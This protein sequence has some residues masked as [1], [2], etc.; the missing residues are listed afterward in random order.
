MLLSCGATEDSW[1]SLGQ[2]GDQTRKSLRKSTL[3]I[4]W[5][6]G[7]WSQCSG[8]LA[9]WCEEPT[10]WKRPWFWGRLKAGGEGGDRG[11]DGWMASLIQWTRVLADSEGQKP[12][13]LQSMGS[14]SVEHDLATEQWKQHKWD[15]ITHISDLSRITFVLC[16]AYPLEIPLVESIFLFI[17]SSW[18][19]LGFLPMWLMSFTSYG[20]FSAMVTMNIPSPTFRCLL[21]ELC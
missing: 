5:K 16:G 1:E 7:C 14:Q 2:E 6:D 15:R 12:G 19:L 21:L 13:V 3:T 18:K 11:W 17:Y 20:K 10:H 9:T 8:T 4:H